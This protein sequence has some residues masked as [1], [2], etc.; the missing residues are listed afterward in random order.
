MTYTL[1]RLISH[2]FSTDIPGLAIR[3]MFAVPRDILILTSLPLHIIFPL[4]K[5]LPIAMCQTHP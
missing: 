1:L 4:P 2:H 5:M 3:K